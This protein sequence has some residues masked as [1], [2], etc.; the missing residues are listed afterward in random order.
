VTAGAADAVAVFDL[1]KTNS[2]LIVFGGDGATLDERRTRPVWREERGLR[3]LDD[4]TLFG[5]MWTSL[6]EA[7]ERHGVRHVV[8]SGHG[9]TFALVAGDRLVHPI[10]D[11]EQEPP[12]AVAAR[13]EPLLPPFAETLSPRLPLG[14]NVGR[15][16]LWLRERAPE[17]FEAADAVLLYPQFW[18]RRLGGAPASEVS[19]LG[20]HT[21]LWA[22]LRRDYSSLV[23]GAGWRRLMPPLAPA[24]A[25]VG[26]ADVPLPS[27][28]TARI[29]VHNGVHD[30]NASLRYHRSVRGGEGFTL[31][32]SG[33]WVIVFNPDC[34]P[35]ALDENRD[36]LANVGV[37]GDP[38]PTIRF[39]GGREFDVASG[40]WS[41]PIGADAVA[42]VVAA[43]SMALPAFAPAGPLAG[44]QGR[45]EGPAVEGERRAAAA[46]LYVA[47]TTDLALDLIHSQNPIVVDGG[48]ARSDLFGRILAALRP[49]QTVTA[50][51][52]AEG[53]ALGAAAL[54]F[55]S[56]GT[57]PFRDE[58]R[59]LNPL[60]S[61]QL[62]AYRRRWRERVGEAAARRG[63]QGGAAA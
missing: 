50:S 52:N 8:V 56:L 28:G 11:Y 12:A 24:G 46:L 34:P 60:D 38:V 42:A 17:A 25:P 53:S 41:G 55:A 15:H 1:G 7:A 36:M 30:S 14:L 32:S 9:C 37:D 21:H 13:I 19:Y 39:M 26:G 5:W 44:R 31:V 23:D 6:G 48:L 20:C 2:K 45:F 4:E 51:P 29:A 54:V 62:T 10:L 33:T 49:A 35:G 59:E 57:A 27:G 58:G 40:G 16:M 61:P 3:V 63:S 18:T 43:G 22:P 47:L